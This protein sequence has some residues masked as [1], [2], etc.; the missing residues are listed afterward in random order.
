MKTSDYKALLD[1]AT[2]AKRD[3]ERAVGAKEAAL[4]RMKEQFEVES[5]GE[6]QALL[7]ELTA[8][9][10]AADVALDEAAE[11]FKTTWDAKLG[12]EDDD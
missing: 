3:Y 8:K 6:A 12:L 4:E 10:D 7:A 5:I 2:K 9:A 11:D 1:N